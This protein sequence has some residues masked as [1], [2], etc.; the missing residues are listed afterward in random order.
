MTAVERHL[1]PL[2]LRTAME[3]G[4][5]NA[6]AAAF[7]PDA[8]F[9]SPL[10]GRLSFTGREQIAALTEVILAALEDFHYTDEVRG[11]GSAMLVARARIGGQDIEIADHLRLRPD[12]T[13][14]EMTVFF[15]P[16]PAAA[17]ALR[18]IGAAFG[19]R[20]SRARGV[21]ISA[22]AWPLAFF[23]RTGDGAG[24]RLI[25]PTL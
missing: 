7:A 16:L 2:P 11:P 19:R 23:S 12:G 22:M 13:I 15:R 9:H 10:T 8:V 3:A 5:V 17:A 24:V 14:G 25:R 20:K 18:V 1:D 6:V 4:D 21:L